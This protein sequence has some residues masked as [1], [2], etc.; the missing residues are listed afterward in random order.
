MITPRVRL[1]ACA[2]AVTVAI[3]GCSG[4][5]AVRPPDTLAAAATTA[6]ADHQRALAIELTAP[7]DGAAGVI[8][9]INGPNILGVAP[10]SGF[11]LVAAPTESKGRD[12]IDVLVTGPLQTGVIAWLRVKGVNS[13]Q[14]YRVTVTQVA[15]GAND[16][17]V[18][19][20]PGAYTLAVRR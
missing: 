6:A 1:F 12:Q 4:E 14:P 18:Q 11:D 5:S 17:F 3:I 10:A 13:G 2:A 9:S 20:D 8:F 15:A 7:L 19:R 16:G